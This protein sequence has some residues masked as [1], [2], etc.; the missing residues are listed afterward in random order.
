MAYNYGPPPSSYNPGQGYSGLPGAGN[1]G[2]PPN[3]G[4]A[5]GMGPPPGVAAAQPQQQGGIPSNFANV[6]LPANINFSAPVIRMGGSQPRGGRGFEAGG[7]DQMGGNRGRAGLGM[8]SGSRH[9]RDNNLAP[10]TKEEVQRTIYVGGLTEGTP[11]DHI[12]EDI[13]G[14]GHG[15]RRWSRVTDAD[16][17][18]LDF[19]FAE[20]EDAASLE[21]ASELFKALEVPI[22]KQGVAEKDEEGNVKKTKLLVIVDP[23]SDEYISQWSKREETQFQFKVDT[24]KDDLRSIIANYVNNVTTVDDLNGHVVENGG[25]V[26]QGVESAEMIDVP[27]SAEDEL[28]DIPA[29][30][31]EMVAAEIAA[32]RERSN[33]RDM[34]RLKMEEEVE[35]SERERARGP[36]HNRIN[37]LATPPPTE[38]KGTN[39]V[40]TGPKGANIPTGPKGQ[41]QT[42]GIS[43]VDPVEVAEDD[44]ASDSEI[45]RCVQAKRKEQDDKIYAEKERKWLARE[46]AH[47]AAVDRQQ[48]EDDHEAAVRD[49]KR[50]EVLQFLSTFDDEDPEI[51]R[52]HLF[53]TDRKA[54]RN[55]RRPARNEERDDDANDRK[56]EARELEAARKRDERIA[57]GAA[58][59]FLDETAQDMAERDRRVKKEEPGKNAFSLSLGFG[60]VKTED[61]D[62]TSPAKNAFTD[63]E[64]LLGAA[65]EDEDGAPRLGLRELDLKPLQPGEKMTEE[66]RARVRMDLARSIPDTAGELFDYEVKWEGLTEEMI[67]RELR[68]YV[69]KK[70][71]ESLGVQEELLVTAIENVIKRHGTAREVQQELEETLD[72]EAEVVTKQVWKMVVFFSESGA[73]GL[74][75]ER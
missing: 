67:M 26:M 32:F 49:S 64:T 68:P 74:L 11:P 18:A 17:K 37:R 60:G 46:K 33:K 21:I 31:R 40:P 7:R 36:A 4:S 5:P 61:M 27:Q 58:D 56:A 29:D 24:A 66:Q 41:K 22:K 14:A 45:E 69:E 43:F 51:R 6:Q 19:G 8:D 20:Y 48:A 38:P 54:W 42:N 44:P 2:P 39:G 75:T 34:E 12:L 1:L 73:R 72:D 65:E 50:A 47:F 25:D 15:L 30:M 28:S 52:E 59:R 63:M 9:P 16:G 10:P 35:R 70:V 62:D 13:L 71:M 53:Y 3:T 57:R 55:A 23:K